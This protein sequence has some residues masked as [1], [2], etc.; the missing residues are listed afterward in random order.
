M[1]THASDPSSVGRGEYADYLELL[2]HK[3]GVEG[4]KC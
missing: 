4:E 3:K 1:T 2:A